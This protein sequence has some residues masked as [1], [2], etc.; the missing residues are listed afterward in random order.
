MTGSRPNNRCREDVH[1]YF[2]LNPCR[3]AYVFFSFSLV[4]MS[5]SVVDFELRQILNFHEHAEARFGEQIENMKQVS[6]SQPPAYWTENLGGYSRGELADDQ[7]VELCDLSRLN[8]YFGIVITYAVFERFLLDVVHS[9]KIEIESDSDYT[10]E[11]MDL[12]RYGEFL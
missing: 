3:S 9:A 10:E 4:S 5:R 8:N 12:R 6:E 1:V 2:L 7:Y 11:K